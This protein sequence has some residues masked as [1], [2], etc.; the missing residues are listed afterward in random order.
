MEHPQI[1][2]LYL[3]S[4]HSSPVLPPS[5]LPAS[6]P[7]HSASSLALHVTPA[8][9]Y[10]ASPPLSPV[11]RAK[12]LLPDVIDLCDDDDETNLSEPY[13]P[14]P[15]HPSS[16]IPH[17]PV[18]VLPPLV[19][20]PAPT[21]SCI[22]DDTTPNGG[23]KTSTPSVFDETA[24]QN[25]DEEDWALFA[26]RPKPEKDDT[27]AASTRHPYPP[28]FLTGA[29]ER[30]RDPDELIPTTHDQEP[31]LDDN[32][33]PPSANNIMHH[34]ITRTRRHPPR[35]R[36]TPTEIRVDLTTPHALRR[37]TQE[38][39]N[40]PEPTTTNS[41]RPSNDIPTPGRRHRIRNRR[42]PS[43][44]QIPEP[45]TPLDEDRAASLRRRI[46][47]WRDRVAYDTP[48]RNAHPHSI[49]ALCAATTHFCFE[50]DLRNYNYDYD[51]EDMRRED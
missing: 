29:L 41:Q 49:G 40:N 31:P 9:E 13:I 5:P 33:R 14:I 22:E 21:L 45:D 43:R 16:P 20:S 11:P 39:P 6:S 25:N 18:P 32:F 28:L 3:P 48:S 4:T 12:S 47:K 38:R 30:P 1:N 46:E 44:R 36:Q 7:T 26:P 34:A 8:D 51:Y 35:P 27:V 15:L 10:P 24:A 50:P 42:D 19:P 37:D 2:Q 17:A 23:V